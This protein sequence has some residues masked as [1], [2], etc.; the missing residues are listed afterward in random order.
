[1]HLEN[2]RVFRSPKHPVSHKGSIALYI[3]SLGSVLLVLLGVSFFSQRYETIH[4]LSSPIHEKV[5][6][7]LSQSVKPLIL[8]ALP[9]T[10]SPEPAL[11]Q[12]NRS[13][14]RNVFYRFGLISPDYVLAQ[15]GAPAL[16][17]SLYNSSESLHKLFSDLLNHIDSE[18]SLSLEVH[19]KKKNGPLRDMIDT[20]DLLR[21]KK[22]HE[23][24]G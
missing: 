12:D 23:A 6:V 22:S 14:L 17:K 20:F 10:S 16:P 11:I 5:I 21:E 13:I 19:V 7:S 15:I 1:M 8:P 2:E 4:Q 18:N 3:G 9:I 24:F